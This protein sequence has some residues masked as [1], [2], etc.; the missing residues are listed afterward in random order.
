MKKIH[1]FYFISPDET[2]LNLLSKDFDE[3]IKE[4]EIKNQ[5]FS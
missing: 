3:K 2:S 5:G 1:V 4:E